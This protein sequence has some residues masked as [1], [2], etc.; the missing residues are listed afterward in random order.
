MD[1]FANIVLIYKLKELAEIA[2]KLNEQLVS[3]QVTST[4]I[5]LIERALYLAYNLG[6][7]VNYN[8]QDFRIDK[9]FPL[10]DMTNET[11]F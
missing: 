8:R 11:F 5:Q 6:F 7:G 2:E 1:W 10:K 3:E 4:R 9:D